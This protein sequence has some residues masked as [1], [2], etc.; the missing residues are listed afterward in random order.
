MY[1]IE[2]IKKDICNRI[3]KFDK[4]EIY[5]NKKKINEIENIDDIFEYLFM[6]GCEE[7]VMTQQISQR[8]TS[9]VITIDKLIEWFGE[10][11]L[12]NKNVYYCGQHLVYGGIKNIIALGTCELEVSNDALVFGFQSSKINLKQK[13]T[14]YAIDNCQFVANNFS[15]VY[16]MEKSNVD[17]T[18]YNYSHCTNNSNCAS[19][20]CYDNTEVD[21]YNGA[22]VTAFDSSVV[23]AYNTSIV[24]TRKGDCTVYLYNSSTCF[25]WNPNAKLHCYD[26]TIT[27]V[28]YVVDTKCEI[29]GH[30]MATHNAIVKLYSKT[31]KIQAYGHCVICDYTDTHSQPFENAFILW[32]NKMKTWYKSN[33]EGKITFIKN[34]EQPN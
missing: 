13:A 7:V 18:L 26:N 2:E 12:T 14:L 22:K 29:N 27:N 5:I 11:Y 32:M 19:I 16:I 1:T 23:R 24:I 8:L 10:E 3:D 21:L 25:C 34:E 17:G 20:E 15:N 30:I 33:D 6:F 31:K 28:E 9:Q 4:D